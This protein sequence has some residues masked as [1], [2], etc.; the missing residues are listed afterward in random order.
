MRTPTGSTVV[1]AGDR[2]FVIC[3]AGEG[4]DFTLAAVMA[5]SV[6]FAVSRSRRQ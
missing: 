6:A 5:P 2:T 1:E 3:D 4:Q